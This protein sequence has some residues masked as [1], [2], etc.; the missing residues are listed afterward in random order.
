MAH[1]HARFNV[2]RFGVTRYGLADHPLVFLVG[3]STKTPAVD[4]FQIVS[5]L[6]G[7]PSVCTFTLVQ[8]TKPTLWGD[9]TLS[10]GGAL[11][12]GGTLTEARARVQKILAG[13]VY[14][15]C[16]AIDWTWLMDRFSRVTIEFGAG[17]SVNTAIAT[18]LK[19]YT[20]GGF[21]TGY[22]PWTLGTIGP[23]SITGETVSASIRRIAAAVNAFVRI[24]PDKRVDVFQSLPSS[25]ALTIGNSS[26]IRDV[27]YESSGSQIRTRVFY[28]GGGGSTTALV[29]AGAA[30]V[31]VDECGWYSG[32]LAQAGSD[33]FAYTGR[34]VSSG[35]GSLTGCSGIAHDLPQGAP[36]NVVAQADDVA[37]QAALSA[38]LG[39]GRSG[40]AVGWF[41][42]GRLSQSEVASRASADLTF[43][44]AEI[45]A[46]GYT[47]TKRY[48]EPGKVVTV[49][50][51]DPLSITGDFR[52]QRVTTRPYG[53]VT[54]NDPTYFEH[55]VECRLA[56]RA[57]ILDVVVG[58]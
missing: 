7:S 53:K 55:I 34:S 56:R 50:V 10:L 33:L 36:V 57:D 27:G 39:G 52:I 51:T 40:I 25:N 45:P 21:A 35:P 23:M 13:T 31:P 9:V 26:E 15:Q 30:S 47:T 37:A 29:S 11:I 16:Q 44:K 42:D 46:F 43:Y 58:A 49:S 8:P 19:N 20:D 5:A 4:D 3:G 54:G 22:I 24:R 28:V 6:D 1:Y 12:W 48:H 32:F 18:L 14:Y 2:C 38:S 41:V 17:T